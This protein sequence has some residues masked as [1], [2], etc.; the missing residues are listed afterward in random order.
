MTEHQ[1]S[2]PEHQDVTLHRPIAFRED[3]AGTLTTIEPPRPV[4]AHIAFEQ[5]PGPLHLKCF[6]IASSEV[7]VLVQCAWQGRL[8]E[9]LV[10][11]DQVFQ[12]TLEPR[13]H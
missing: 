4:W 5:I 3:L 10:D 1:W 11:R 9:I 6:A 13:A 12:R 8:Q 2:P 7:A